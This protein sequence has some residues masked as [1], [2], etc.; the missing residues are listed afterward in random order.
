MAKSE[1]MTMGVNRIQWIDCAKTVAIVAVVVDHCYLLLY[2]NLYIA[3]ASHFSVGLFVLLSGITTFISGSKKGNS[4]RRQLTK[5]GK[6]TLQYMLAVFA[7]LIVSTQYFDLRTYLQYFVNFNIQGPYYFLVFYFQLLL[8][9]PLLI[10]WCEFCETRKY[11]LVWHMVTLL[12]LTWLSSMAIR[13]TCILPVHGGGYY[14]AGGT[15]I[16]LFYLGILLMRLDVLGKYIWKFR[17][18]VLVVCIMLSIGWL[19]GRMHGLFTLDTKLSPWFG[20]GFNP[21]GF[22]TMIYTLFIFLI[23]YCIFTLLEDN[24]SRLAKGV[25]KLFSWGGNY[26][27]YIFLHHQLVM[28]LMRNRAP[29]FLLNNTWSFR[30]IVFIPALVLPVIIAKM[31]YRVIR[32][33]QNELSRANEK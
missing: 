14:L 7:V 6:V 19:E 17:K 33:I 24:G 12:G 5:I 30:V 26:T 22:E 8:L 20:P 21:P 31:Y 18:I 1:D 16:L 23:S 10:Y 28:A 32:Y 15:Y 3:E 25:I 13:Y 27:L 11:K 29:A 4:W 9:A 2:D